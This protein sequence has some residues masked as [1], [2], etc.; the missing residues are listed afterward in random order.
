MVEWT[1]NIARDTFCPLP[2]NHLATNPSGRLRLCC[3]SDPDKNRLLNENGQSILINKI[4]SLEFL[5]QNPTLKN[6]RKMMLSGE[7]PDLCVRCFREEDSGLTSARIA[8]LNEYPIL[9]WALENTKQD[10]TTTH[11]I[12]YIDLRLGNLCNLKCRMCNPYSSNQ[13]IP[14]AHE[15]GFINADEAERLKHL[16]WGRDPNLWTLFHHYLSSIEV[17]YLTGGEPTIILEQMELL[18]ICINSGHAKNIRLK[19]NTNVTNIKEQFFD[20]WKHFKSVQLNCSVDGLN[21]LCRYIRHPSNWNAINRNLIKIDQ[22]ATV[23]NIKAEIHVTVQIA[24][25]TRLIEIFEY[26]S[27]FKNIERFPYL[28]ILNHPEYYN[29]RVL[30]NNLKNDITDELEEWKNQNEY[31]YVDH[32]KIRFNKLDGLIQYMN[33]EDW[34]KHSALF[35]KYTKWYD[36]KR[37]EDFRLIAPKLRTW[38]DSL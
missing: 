10:G 5:D 16:D 18:K 19:Y 20:F 3:N 1:S 13:L 29:V 21:D 28:N 8:Y 26:I 15:L 35:K 9:D 6:I 37:G 24:N 4:D 27:N 7:R 23:T 38:F 2:W 22:L 12:E 31:R 11:R 25:I 36:K 14:E 34:T 17:I 33:N 32:E 30:P